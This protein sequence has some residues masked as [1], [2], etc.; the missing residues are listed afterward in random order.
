VRPITTYVEGA[1]VHVQSL[2]VIH[3]FRPFSVIY[4]VD[5][6]LPRVLPSIDHIDTPFRLSRRPVHFSPS[7]ELNLGVAPCQN[8]NL[9]YNLNR[10]IRL[11]VA[12]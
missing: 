9:S 1:T 7:L 8:P 11:E 2:R 10:I 12:I 3:S 4:S 5:Q 6:P